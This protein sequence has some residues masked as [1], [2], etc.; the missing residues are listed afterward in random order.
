MI[1]DIK[2]YLV[3]EGHGTFGTDLFIGTQPGSPDVITSLFD[4]GGPGPDS[5]LFD[6]TG[7]IS[8][9]TF[10]VYHRSGKAA[11]S[12]TNGVDKIRDIERSLHK[13]RNQQLGTTYFY[14]IF[15]I[16]RGGDIGQDDEGRDEWSINFQARI[17]EA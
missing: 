16:S 8:E 5:E 12:Y 11:G 17:R 1:D 13:V 15:A 10:Q 14:Y 7:T 4:T 2:N 9:V 3:T 6:D